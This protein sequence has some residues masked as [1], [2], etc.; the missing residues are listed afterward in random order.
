M[1]KQVIL[2]VAVMSIGTVMMQQEYVFGEE[3]VT[4]TL[5]I[6]ATCGLEA[7][8]DDS[9][10]SVDPGNISDVLQIDL[11]NTG[12]AEMSVEVYVS[13]WLS[14]TDLV[15]NGERTAYS[16]D[17]TDE[18]SERI[19]L[20]NTSLPIDMGTIEAVTTN[21]TYWQVEAILVDT[22]FSGSIQQTT[23]FDTQCS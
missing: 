15:I 3:S 16:D 4:N 7:I 6:L 17:Q 23:V 8:E 11:E 12:N 10:G 1:I 5:T 9:F 21:Q 14:G 18:Y 13:D 22:S 19:S 2:L 20:N